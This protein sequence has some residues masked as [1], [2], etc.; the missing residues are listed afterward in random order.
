MEKYAQFILY[1]LDADAERPGKMI[2]R[3]L[4]PLTLIVSNP[5][6]STIWQSYAMCKGVYDNMSTEQRIHYGIGFVFTDSDPF[7]FVDIDDC[8]VEGAWSPLAL[9]ILATLPGVYTEVSQSG[10]G[11]HLIGTGVPPAHRSKST[12]HPGLELYHTKRFVALT[13]WHPV[14]SPDVDCSSVLPHLVARY[15]TGANSTMPGAGVGD[16][17]RRWAAALAE[18]V[19]TAWMGPTDDSELLSMAQRSV[20]ASAAFG[21]GASFN[22]LWMGNLDVLPQIYGDDVSFW[23]AALAQHL[24]FWTGNDA[25]RIQRLML[26]SGLWRDKYDREDYLPRTILNARGKQTVFLNTNKITHTQPQNSQPSGTCQPIEPLPLQKTAYPRQ[27]DNLKPVN[28][29]ENL[30]FLLR[31]LSITAR[32]NDMA[33][34]R[35]VVIPG[36]SAYEGDAENS[37]LNRVIDIAGHNNLPTTRIDEQLTAIAQGNHY[38]PIVDSILGTPWDGIPRWGDFIAQIKTF[39][40]EHAHS[41]I[42]RWMLSAIAAAFSERGFAQQG[43]LVLEGPQG[44]GKTQWVKHLDP[45]NCKAVKEGGLLDPTDK[46]T[47]IEL[48]SHWIVELGELDGSFRK[49][50][51]ARIKS[52]LTSDCDRV[53]LPYARKTT[54]I[55]RRTAYVAT[56]NES[57]YLTDLTG[58][59]RWWTVSVDSIELNHGMDLQQVWAEAYYYWMQGEKTWLDRK[60]IEELHDHNAQ[61]EQLDPFEDLLLNHFDWSEGWETKPNTTKMTCAELL[62]AIGYATPTR[63][64]VTRISYLIMKHTKKKANRRLHTLPSVRKIK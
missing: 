42:R 54:V 9:E 37:I 20:S 57:R 14:G 55:P 60:Q 15:F 25:E 7:F 13:Y 4:N 39:N 1:R 8:V 24:C 58:N 40:S 36:F 27:T 46:D 33:H 50:D 47:I 22:D 34:K 17:Y 16:L 2:K 48:A 11:L 18:G 6:D 41:L 30:A 52:Y 3:P 31:H 45:I 5:H 35:E 38:H 64:D 43:A 28:S 56:V 49:S 23:D 53:R 19:N 63:A 21:A 51:T 10:R 32:W 59:R 26:D 62:R 12:T 44:V 29:T 61:Y